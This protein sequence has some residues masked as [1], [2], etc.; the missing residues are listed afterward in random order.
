M[1]DDELAGEAAAGAPAI[2]CSVLKLCIAKWEAAG[3]VICA[4]IGGEPSTRPGRALLGGWGGSAAD[5]LLIIGAAGALSARAT[6]EAI[7][8]AA[9]E[10]DNIA[11]EGLSARAVI[12]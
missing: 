2:P 12:G 3:V 6:G 10:V 1:Y 8:L 11:T 9:R 4:A 7:D 5:A